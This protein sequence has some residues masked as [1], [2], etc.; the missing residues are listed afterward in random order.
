[1]AGARWRAPA[2]ADVCAFV[3]L[4]VQA[5]SLWRLVDL[6]YCTHPASFCTVTEECLMR[7]DAHMAAEQAAAEAAG[8]QESKGSDGGKG[9]GSDGGPV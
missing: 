1:M 6:N 2:P 8:G 9:R 5:T 7:E 4:V 3:A